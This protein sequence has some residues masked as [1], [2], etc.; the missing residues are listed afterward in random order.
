M[1]KK[2][3]IYN[4]KI[5]VYVIFIKYFLGFNSVEDLIINDEIIRNAHFKTIVYKSKILNK[6]LNTVI[7]FT[8]TQ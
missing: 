5:I 1:Y 3:I 8:D 2:K 6:Q 7:L 4:E